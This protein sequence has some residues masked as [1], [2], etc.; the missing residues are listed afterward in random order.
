MSLHFGVGDLTVSGSGGTYALGKVHN[1]SINLSY[2]VAQ[3]RGGND[4]FAMNTQFYDGSIDGSF[5][6]AD[7]ELSSLGRLIAGTGAFAGAAN[8]GTITLTGE[9]RPGLRAVANKITNAFKLVFSGVT[10]GITSTISIH[11]VY[12]PSLTLDF[13]RTDYMVPGMTFVCEY[14]TGTG[15][16]TIQG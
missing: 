16:M 11:R 4:I 8:S 9:S 15:L 13:T 14:G 1:V 7:L 12:I 6:H 3:L 2:E 10:D 5:D